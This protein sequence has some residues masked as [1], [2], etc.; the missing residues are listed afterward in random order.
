M[1]SFVRNNHNHKHPDS[2]DDDRLSDSSDNNEERRGYRVEYAGDGTDEMFCIN[3]FGRDIRIKQM[4][5]D[6]VIGHGAVVWEAAV[7]FAK[8][9]EYSN[10]KDLS[11]ETLRRKRVLELGSGTGLAGMCVMLRGAQV[12]M[13][14][15]A[16]VT[17]TL[18]F[19]NVLQFYKQLRSEGSGA[20]FGIEIECPRVFSLDWTDVD[21]VSK[22]LAY[23]A[24][25][26]TPGATTVKVDDVET[27]NVKQADTEEG[28]PLWEALTLP[29]DIV[30]LTDCV[31]S[32]HL[33][34]DLVRTI[35]QCTG[36]KSIVY[37]V[38][39]IRD[40]EANTEFLR[41]LGLHFKVKIAPM[42]DQHPDFRHE[43][44]QIVIAKPRRKV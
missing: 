30:L 31:F 24:P 6:R 14:D 20:I 44:V 21:G 36:P 19:A 38:H 7:V 10:K 41:V 32:I 42:K 40:T 33:V 13:T 25:I 3:V 34:P 28:C 37:C 26:D 1:S 27:D 35:Q 8:Y 18:T 4:P 17:E 22:M 15:L 9:M 16:C 23:A 5:S 12:T 43:L 39:E 11:V 29:Y 2:D